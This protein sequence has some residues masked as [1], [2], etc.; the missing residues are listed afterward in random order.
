MGIMKRLL[1]LLL[2]HA[3]ALS[4]GLVAL[5]WAPLVLVL[6]L[7][8][9]GWG[10]LF[11]LVGTAALGA[12]LATIGALFGVAAV[13]TGRRGRK[14]AP[15]SAALVANLITLFCLLGALL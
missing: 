4:W 15:A 11:M 1:G 14:R 5:A 7:V 12:L 8:E 3:T 2:K 10:Q 13:L 6:L 9:E